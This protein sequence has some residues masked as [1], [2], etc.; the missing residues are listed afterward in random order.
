[1]AI[2][3]LRCRACDHAFQ[4]VTRGAVKQK[5]KQC[6]SCGSKDVRQTF[7]SYLRNGPLSDPKCGEPQCNTSYG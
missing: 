1:M 5:Q 2:V 3:D 7:G 4:L 6:P